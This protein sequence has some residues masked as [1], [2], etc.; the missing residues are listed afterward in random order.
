MRPSY[1]VAWDTRLPALAEDAPLALERIQLVRDQNASASAVITLTVSTGSA[2]RRGRAGGASPACPRGA[3][4]CGRPRDG[5]ADVAR[6]PPRQRR[7]DG[8][9]RGRAASRRGV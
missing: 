4:C 6:V 9:R 3:G 5:R 8:G 7:P 2:S 1:E